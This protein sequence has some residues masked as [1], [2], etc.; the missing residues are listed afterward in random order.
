[1]KRLCLARP[2]ESMV[3]DGG[4]MGASNSVTVLCARNSPQWQKTAQ[5]VIDR[6]FADLY[7]RLYVG[8]V[9]NVALQLGCVWQEGALISLL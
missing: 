2:P 4:R 7:D 9:S 6:Y 3:L 8:V 5:L 1:M